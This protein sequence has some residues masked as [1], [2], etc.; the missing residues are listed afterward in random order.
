MRLIILICTAALTACGHDYGARYP[1]PKYYGYYNSAYEGEQDYTPQFENHVNLVHITGNFENPVFIQN[2]LEE[3]R[4]LNLKAL[5]S[6]ETLFFNETT[7]TPLPNAKTNWNQ[8]VP[9][10]TQYQDVIIAFYVIDE[11]EGRANI[12]GVNYREIINEVETEI[13]IVK[14]SFPQIAT[15]YIEDSTTA[16]SA[17]YY[18]PFN[19]DWVGV[20]CYT[21]F[22][23]CGLSGLSIPSY[24]DLAASRM[25]VNQRFILIPPTLTGLNTLTEQQLIVINQQ[26]AAYA[27]Q[28]SRVIAILP[29]IWQSYP[30]WGWTGA[31][32]LPNL[33]FNLKQISYDFR[34][35]N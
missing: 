7:L 5:V 33:L 21:S 1:G 34:S 10:F 3:C 15:A 28:N 25:V 2:K 17:N 30:D 35:Q 12:Y 24:Y 26:Y 32:D 16:S 6:I 20:D 9:L 19:V 29:F 27:Q 18:I 14:N 22:T 13:A 31:N 8:I 23:S 4:A 11:P